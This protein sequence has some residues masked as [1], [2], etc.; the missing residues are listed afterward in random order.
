M[1]GS[2]RAPVAASRARPVPSAAITQIPRLASRWLTNTIQGCAKPPAAH[3]ATGHRHTTDLPAMTIAHR[4]PLTATTTAHPG[5]A[6]APSVGAASARPG[7]TRPGQGRVASGSASPQRHRS[8]RVAL[9]SFVGL[10]RHPHDVEPGRHGQ[11]CR[12]LAPP[13]PHQCLPSLVWCPAGQSGRRR[14]GLDHPNIGLTSPCPAVRRS[15][16]SPPLMGRRGS[17]QPRWCVRPWR[18]TLTC[19]MARDWC[20]SGALATTSTR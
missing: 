7:P 15:Q 9:P 20:P 10:R 14:T 17:P 2:P 4:P 16:R 12:L 3:K 6:H 8:H 11:A 13:L 1:V 18:P 19:V 5:W